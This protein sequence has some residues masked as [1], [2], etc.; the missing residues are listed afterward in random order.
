MVDGTLYNKADTIFI[1]TT[2]KS[3]LE[4]YLAAE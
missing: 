3:I 4:T 1:L 2:D